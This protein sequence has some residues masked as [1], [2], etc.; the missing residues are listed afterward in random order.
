VQ[1]VA[2][3]ARDSQRLAYVRLFECKLR[4]ALKMMQVFFST[5]NKI[6]QAQDR[7]AF[8]QQPITQIRSQKAGRSSYDCP[9]DAS[10]KFH[11]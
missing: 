9:H 10:K 7:P 11:F 1:N 5:G 8:R 4:V 2:N 3:V 6:V